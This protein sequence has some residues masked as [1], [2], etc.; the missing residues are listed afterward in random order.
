MAMFTDNNYSD[1]SSDSEASEDIDLN[2]DVS[3]DMEW[4]QYSDQLKN[5]LDATKV[6]PSRVDE[7]IESL[8]DLNKPIDIDIGVF[9]NIMQS[10]TNENG[11]PGPATTL[12]QSLSLAKKLE[13]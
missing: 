7:P 9:N 4:N 13:S 2:K 6:M 1:E 12:L 3:N 8:D 10:Y 5:E 11:I